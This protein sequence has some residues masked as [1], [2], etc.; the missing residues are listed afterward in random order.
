MMSALEGE[1]IIEKQTTT[2]QC[3]MQTRGGVKKSENFAD[4]I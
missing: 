2:N 1:G 4:V 3:Q